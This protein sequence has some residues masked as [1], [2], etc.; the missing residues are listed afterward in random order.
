ML[1]QTERRRQSAGG[2]ADS[3]RMPPR[4]AGT[5]ASA[6][7]ERSD[8]DATAPDSDG[9]GSGTLPRVAQGEV[10]E[11]LPDDRGDR[12]SVAIRRG[13]LHNGHTSARRCRTKALRD[14]VY[15]RWHLDGHEHK[16]PNA[17]GLAEGSTRVRRPTFPDSAMMHSNRKASTSPSLG[18]SHG[19]RR[20]GEVG[21]HVEAHLVRE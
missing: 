21:G 5:T 9:A 13:G 3:A 19:R 12:C 20:A 18:G 14:A 4:G 8:Q 11:D 6:A 17:S 15:R 1:G 2:P 10:R 7:P 16:V